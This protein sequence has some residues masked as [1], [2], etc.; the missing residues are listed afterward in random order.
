MSGVNLLIR[1]LIPYS[2]QRRR[3]QWYRK[4]AEFFLDIRTHNSFNLWL[5]LSPE[6]E[7]DHLTCYLNISLSMVSSAF[8]FLIGKLNIHFFRKSNE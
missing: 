8:Y 4:I 7:I 2:S 6:N 3:V 5:K 1:F